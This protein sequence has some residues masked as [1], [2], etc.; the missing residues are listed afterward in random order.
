MKKI[1]VAEATRA[2]F[3]CWWEPA[4][5]NRFEA[6]HIPGEKPEPKPAIAQ[7]PEMIGELRAPRCGKRKRFEMVEDQIA[8]GLAYPTW[9]TGISQ[10]GEPK[11]MAWRLQFRTA[12]STIRE[13]EEAVRHLSPQEL[14]EFRRWF[15][16]FDA[17]AWDRQLEADARAG[18]L[19]K[20]ADKALGDLR[21]GRCNDL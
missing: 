2:D 20:L 13:I 4:G 18:R 7:I 9:E 12:M 10:S 5:D 16:E 15:A 14:T 3:V 21:Q 1:Q 6:R 11:T 17:A 8:H 19:D